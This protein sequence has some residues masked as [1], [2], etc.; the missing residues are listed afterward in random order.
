MAFENRELLPRPQLRCDLAL[1]RDL[2][3]EWIELQPPKGGFQTIRATLRADI[4]EE[5]FPSDVH[6]LIAGDGSYEG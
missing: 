5:R 1:A 2:R 4:G 3:A 6:P